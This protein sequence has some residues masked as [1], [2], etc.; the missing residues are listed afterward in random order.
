MIFT[1]EAKVWKRSSQKSSWHFATLPSKF[2][3]DIK[4]NCPSGKGFGSVRVVAKIGQI[5]WKTSIFLSKQHKSYI[6][7]IKAD[8]RR[9]CSIEEGTFCKIYIETKPNFL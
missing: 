1:F 5:Q 7:P 6:L 4:I 3:P 9:R 8:I 2:C